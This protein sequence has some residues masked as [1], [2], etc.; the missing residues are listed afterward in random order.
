[1]FSQLWPA[2]DLV[3]KR[4]PGVG[5]Q[6]TFREQARIL[7]EQTDAEI[8]YLAEDDYFYLPNEFPLAVDFLRK[9]PGVDFISPYYHP[10]IYTTALHKL[11]PELK[12]ADGKTWQSCMSTTHTFL[13]TRETLKKSSQ[14]VLA[15]Y[16]KVSPD[17]SKWMALTKRRVFNPVFFV[18]SVFT[19][20]FWAGSVFYA[21]RYLWRQI[22]FGQKFSLWIPK[23]TIATHMV[24]GLEAP[25][26]DWK[27]IF[28]ERRKQLGY[29]I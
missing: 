27:K 15:S 23:P 26:V 12:I 19:C 11:P 2:E 24:A 9:N 5:D 21:W 18:R 4:F 1:M 14:V 10:D 17:L 3:F 16:G 20:P 28:D 29:K 13:T 8:V 25:G 22:L 7:M 6:T